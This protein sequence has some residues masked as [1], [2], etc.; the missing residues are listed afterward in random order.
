MREL[1][2]WAHMHL[3]TVLKVDPN[4]ASHL[5]CVMQVGFN[6][7]AL[8][9]LIRIFNPESVKPVIGVVKDFTTLDRHPEFILYEGYRKR[10]S[11]DVYIKRQAAPEVTGPDSDPFAVP[12]PF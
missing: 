1:P 5:Q 2:Q 9:E 7:N 6:G 11:G 12:H 3:V 8:A 4:Y 10:E